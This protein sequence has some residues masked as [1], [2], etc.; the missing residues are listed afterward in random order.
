[1]NFEEGRH[2]IREGIRKRA[3]KGLAQRTQEELDKIREGLRQIVTVADEDIIEDL[4]AL[5]FT[6]ETVG[7]LPLIPLVQVAWADGEVQGKEAK[8]ILSLTEKRGYE[9]ESE[10]FRLID[11]LLMQRPTDEF[12]KSCLFVL[13]EIYNK[14]PGEQESEAKMNLLG[15]AKR[16]AQ[17]S[18]GF[19]GLFGEKVDASEASLI[20][21][22][23]ATLGAKASSTTSTELTDALT[24][25]TS[26]DDDDAEASDEESD[27]ED[28]P[29]E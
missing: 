23:A 27:T 29:K 6:K 9:I 18:G 28:A 13:K 5:G 14:L 12:M 15:F 7:V 16:V 3:D 10:A 11:N 25:G 2:Y 26:G 17:A 8:E 24:S 21:E 1:M 20:D 22:I 19:L 4:I